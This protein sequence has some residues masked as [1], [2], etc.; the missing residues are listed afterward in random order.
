M[1]VRERGRGDGCSFAGCRP[2]WPRTGQYSSNKLI[3]TFL[4][5]AVHARSTLVLQVLMLAE[6]PSGGNTGL[7]K[8]VT[9]RYMPTCLLEKAHRGAVRI[10]F[11]IPRSQLAR[12]CPEPSRC[13]PKPNHNPN[14]LKI[15]AYEGIYCCLSSTAS[16]PFLPVVGI[17][18]LWP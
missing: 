2:C 1:F 4:V 14:Y 7:Q 6:P 8:T 17:G 3:R 12:L 11:M 5:S 15:L 16:P 18:C 13:S 10:L 9:L